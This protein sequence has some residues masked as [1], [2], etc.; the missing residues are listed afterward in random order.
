MK[1]SAQ[2]KQ[3]S[4]IVEAQ[5]TQ[6]RKKLATLPEGLLRHSDSARRFWS[7]RADTEYAAVPA[8][9]QVVLALVREGAS[10]NTIRAYNTIVDDEIR[11]AALSKELAQRLGG[12]VSAPHLQGSAERLAQPTDVPV[13]VWALA[14]GC[15]S[16][17]VS[18]SLI[19]KRYAK[20][21][22]PL[23]K[24]VLAETLKDE[25]VHVKVAWTLASEV[26]PALTANAKREL[27]DYGREYV[28]MLKQ[29]FGTSNMQGAMKRRET[30][31]RDETFSADLG[32]LSAAEENTIIDETL[33]DI[34]KRLRVYG[35]ELD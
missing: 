11:H 5:H 32:S 13:V 28:H 1:K 6:R 14:N 4:S 25:A 10:L 19:S 12:Y 20:T 21:K 22:T 24:A 33:T 8:I 15:L 3:W 9:S 31:L 29:T 30:K 26:L 35:V 17:T 2:A 27:S 7:Q 18:L 16:E 34:S 23:V